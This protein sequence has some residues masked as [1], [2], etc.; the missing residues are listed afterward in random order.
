M[1]DLVL[2]CIVFGALPFILRR[3]FIGI[4]MLAWL[5]FMNPHRLAWGFMFDMPVVQIVAAFTLVGML[6][7]NEA[8]RMIWSRE[9]IVLAVFIAWMG[10]TTWFAFF[11]DL[12]WEQYVK[13]LKIQ[14]LTVMALLMLTSQQRLHLFIWVIVLSIGF[15]GIKGGIF[16]LMHG[17]VFRVQGPAGSFIASNNDLAMAMAMTVPLMRYLYL[18]E[19]QRLVKLGLGVGM[20]LTVIACFGTQSRGALVALVCMGAMFW[21]KSR[22][23]LGT[24]LLIVLSAGVALA[25]MP[26]E[27]FD[28]MAT[29]QTHEE[30]ASAM[31]RVNQWG[32]AINIA[33]ARLTGG[34]FETWQRPVCERF[35]PNPD[36]C[37][38]VHSIYFEVLGEHGYIGLLLY[39]ALLGLTWFKCSA[40]VRRARG[41]PGLQWAS[42]L[43]AM[44]QVSMVAYLSAGAFLGMAYYDY[45]YR[46]IVVV[47]VTAWLVDR[48]SRPL[49]QAAAAGQATPRAGG[50]QP[51]A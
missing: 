37:R 39:L 14:I 41:D 8:K 2:A 29:I 16:T 24:A 12:A 3:P 38:D 28:R 19:R 22:H 48:A 30:D 45:L 25:T 21:W 49:P 46:L 17:G 11:P 27:W 35:A 18:T 44:I 32:N 31:G 51:D 1:R 36:D 40:I 34:G 26:Q 33:N 13:V 23:K 6:V 15:Y 42:D 9:I 20:F 5:G 47:V 43:A 10:I 50:L 7:S 4:L